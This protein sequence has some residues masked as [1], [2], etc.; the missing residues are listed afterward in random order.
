[1]QVKRMVIQKCVDC[2][3]EY[4]EEKGEFHPPTECPHPTTINTEQANNTIEDKIQ[5]F[6]EKNINK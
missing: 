1:M 5:E 6:E 3:F 2:G 4:D